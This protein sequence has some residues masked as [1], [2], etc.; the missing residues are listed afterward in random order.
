M[1]PLARFFSNQTEAFN[2]AAPRS[3]SGNPRTSLFLQKPSGMV[4]HTGGVS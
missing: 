4:G 3:V 2:F 1:L